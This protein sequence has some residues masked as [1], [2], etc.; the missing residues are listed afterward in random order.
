VLSCP[1][2]LS[3][4]SACVAGIVEIIMGV[5][6]A[7]HSGSMVFASVT[8]GLLTCPRPCVIAHAAYV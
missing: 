2:R 1:L 3:P 4:S 8:C 7:R 6:H 5:A